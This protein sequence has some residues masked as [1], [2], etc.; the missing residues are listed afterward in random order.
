MRRISLL[1][2]G[3]ALVLIA[4]CD[5][6]TPAPTPTPTPTPSP[7][8]VAIRAGQRMLTVESLHFIMELS[9]KLVYLDYPPT[10]ALR[11]AEGDV[12]RPDQVRAIVKVS[13]FG[14]AS[15]IGII[16]IGAD[17]YMTNPLNQQ[18]ERVPP[19]QGWYF[20]PAILFDPEYGIEAILRISEWT[21]GAQ[22]EIEGQTHDVLH[23]QVPGERLWLLSSGMIDS[24]EVMVDVWVNREDASVRRIQLV[25]LGSSEEDPTQWLLLF[26][27]FDDPIDIQAPPIP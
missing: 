11:R 23:G 2:V 22:E 7:A 19:G 25:E 16:G 10:L 6:A 8:D 20:D 5:L 9:G 17:Q 14:V 13:S 26:S 21:F 15:E 3:A 27:D 18:W 12:K 1:F 4:G 24:G